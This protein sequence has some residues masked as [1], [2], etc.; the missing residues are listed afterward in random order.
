M[1][2]YKVVT[3]LI[4]I[5]LDEN[6]GRLFLEIQRDTV[7][8]TAGGPEASGLIHFSHAGQLFATFAQDLKARAKL[9][10]AANQGL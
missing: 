2:L 10:K 6:D 8:T 1:A 3:P 9:V 5:P 7:I 4:A